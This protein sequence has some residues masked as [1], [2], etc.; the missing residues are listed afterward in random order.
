MLMM[1][2]ELKKSMKD[3]KTWSQAVR[4]PL[5]IEEV[6]LMED[7]DCFFCSSWPL[8][9]SGAG[10]S[11]FSTVGSMGSLTCWCFSSSISSNSSDLCGDWAS[12]SFSCVDI[13]GA[14]AIL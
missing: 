6:L 12:M 4:P 14:E 8:A 7:F 1:P 9:R 10:V 3:P 2:Q 13:L 5:G 11:V